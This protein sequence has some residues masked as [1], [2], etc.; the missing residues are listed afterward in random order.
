MLYGII[1]GM[2]NIQLPNQTGYTFSF[3]SD[4]HGQ[5]VH[6]FNIKL[7]KFADS[8]ADAIR[9]AI[10]DVEDFLAKLKG[11]SRELP[12]PSPFEVREQPQ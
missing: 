6:A 4:G 10:A 8:E 2:N 9:L 7:T 5:A 11:R 3:A 1:H 12:T